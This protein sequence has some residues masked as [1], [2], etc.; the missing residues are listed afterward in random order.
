MRIPN[1]ALDVELSSFASFSRGLRTPDSNPRERKFDQADILTSM[2]EM[3]G[4]KCYV[5]KIVTTMYI[6]CI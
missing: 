2:S 1:K 4:T 6:R 3:Y 5:M